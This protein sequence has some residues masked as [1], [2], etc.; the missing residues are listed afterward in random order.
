MQRVSTG[1]GGFHGTAG[2]RPIHD[3]PPPGAPPMEDEEG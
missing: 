1:R 2:F 3:Q